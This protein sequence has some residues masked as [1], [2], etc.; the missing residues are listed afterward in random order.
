VIAPPLLRL[1]QLASPAL[2]I[3]AF[4]YSQGLEH[5]VTAGWV[6][7]EA[8]AR[9]WILGLLQ[10]S[11]ARL[12]V[13]LLA[14]LQ[15]AFA[16][17]DQAQARRWDQELLASRGSAEARAEE[18]R[19]GSSLAR[20]LATLEVAVPWTGSHLA[21]FALAASAWEIPPPTAAG[22]YLFAWTETQVGAAT[23][24]VPLGQSAAQ[25]ILS[26]AIAVV[27]AAVSRGM[28]MSDEE[29]GFCAPAQAMA[30]ALHE[31]QYSR[32]FRS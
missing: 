4:A 19:L 29:I 22:G 10:E 18:Q 30:T 13:P 16:A 14:R 27:P 21:M 32:I 20:L 24:L 9:G 8:A 25:R 7:D 12:E 17:G 23:R 31:T 26:A 15:R 6:P 2:P 3:G 5:A 28:T 11:L 1:L